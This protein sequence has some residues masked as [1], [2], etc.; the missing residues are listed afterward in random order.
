M[1]GYGR[2]KCDL[3]NMVYSIEIK[4]LNSK[5]LDT[6]VKVPLPLREK[7]M[8]IRNM[9]NNELLR[10]KIELSIYY[11]LKESA[12]GYSINQPVVKEYLKQLA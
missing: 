1:T 3:P 9:L 4:S 6:S 12:P 10:G 2:N 11:E 7:E 5:Q 8:E